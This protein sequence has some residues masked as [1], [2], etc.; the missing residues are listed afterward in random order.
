VLDGPE[1][2]RAEKA[3]KDAGN[4]RVDAGVR[5]GRPLQLTLEDPDADERAKR[6]EDAEAR[7]LERADAKK[8]GV[9]GY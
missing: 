1:Q 6:D 9:N 7:D 5:Q 4:R 3:A 2:L 8:N